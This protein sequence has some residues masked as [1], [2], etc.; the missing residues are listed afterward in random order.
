[1]VSVSFVQNA[2]SLLTQQS[3]L[4][5][6]STPKAQENKTKKNTDTQ[7]ANPEENQFA[8]VLKQSATSTPNKPQKKGGTTAN[9]QQ[10]QEAT[11]SLD[12]PAVEAAPLVT[13]TGEKDGLPSSTANATVDET[14]AFNAIVQSE[15][16]LLAT[17][18]NLTASQEA[19][20]TVQ[21]NTLSS[22]QQ[23]ETIQS[24]DTPSTPSAY[25]TETPTTSQNNDSNTEAFLSSDKNPS[26]PENQK[27]T[28]PSTE[29]VSGIASLGSSETTLP[30]EALPVA[31]FVDASVDVPVT[32]VASIVEQV[33][34]K[35]ESVLTTGA[36]NKQ[37]SM[38]LQPEALGA[39][40]VQLQQ[41]SNQSVSGKIIVQTPEAFTALTQQ[42]DGLKTRLENQ[43]INL[44]KLEVVLAPPKADNTIVLDSQHHLAMLE[45]SSS[46]STDLSQQGGSE[47]KSGFNNTASQEEPE[48]FSMDKYRQSS[49]QEDTN[50]EGGKATQQEKQAAYQAH[51][52][53][54]R[55]M[56]SYRSA[57]KG[58]N[59]M[60]YA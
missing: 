35:L 6:E 5:T 33:G 38:V 10:P 25:A 43:G 27:S 24:T 21:K 13:V 40:R 51:L 37:V 20:L 15:L 16:A 12:E 53:E 32:E 45:A 41:G 7:R 44:Q 59:T 23:P 58:S 14:L 29:A 19:T 8:Q 52:N 36:G 48:A 50:Q 55:G 57:L 46:S 1:M 9:K 47:A 18:N 54:L 56:R 60:Q 3:L 30:A 22:L 28:T 2:A 49:N 11:P 39:V 34:G 17:A 26:N 4:L 42:L 31:S